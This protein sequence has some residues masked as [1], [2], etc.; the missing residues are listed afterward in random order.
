[1]FGIRKSK[2]FP[3]F[4]LP[5]PKFLTRKL[6]KV[7]DF[8]VLLRVTPDISILNYM[9]V[10]IMLLFFASASLTLLFTWLAYSF[11]KAPSLL[12]TFLWN[13]GWM[14]LASIY[15]GYTIPSHLLLYAILFWFS[16]VILVGSFWVVSQARRNLRELLA[17]RKMHTM[18]EAER[19]AFSLERFLHVSLPLWLS[20]TVNYE[21]TAEE[22]LKLLREREQATESQTLAIASTLEESVQDEE[23]QDEEQR[24]EVQQYEVQDEEQD[25]QPSLSMLLTLTSSLSLSLIGPGSKNVPFQM[26]DAVASLVGFLATREK[27][28]WTTKDELFRGVYDPGK[29]SAFAM[30][31]KRANKQ[32]ILHARQAGFLPNKKEIIPQLSEENQSIQDSQQ[33]EENT[34]DT[35]SVFEERQVPGTEEKIEIDLFKNQIQGQISS[36]QLIT[37]CNVDVFPFLTDFYRKVVAAQALSMDGSSALSLSLEQL[38]QGCHRIMEEYG[39]GFLAS[40]MKKGYVWTWALPLYR[41]YQDQCLNILAYSNEREREYLNTCQTRE[42]RSEVV[43]HIAQFYGWQASV[44]AG[45]EPQKD[46]VSSERDME[47]CLIYYQRIKKKSAA[48]A[49]YHRYCELR[50][51]SNYTYEPGEALKNR[52]EEVLSSKGKTNRSR[53]P[54]KDAS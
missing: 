45:L 46:D 23:Q 26:T 16:L 39:D 53:K 17:L 41:K 33:D 48:R 52:A 43:E 20:P 3:F 32:V 22:L 27:G 50:S 18:T 7:D 21:P 9:N 42:E 49:T 1:M 47:R 29:E 11:S 30:H 38:R 51:R 6:K 37:D 15:T 25:E 14:L 8:V 13:D 28:T 19:N 44:G 54:E 40:H 2:H 31:R 10:G 36:W 12:F 4:S 5:E 24:D 35:S 34:E